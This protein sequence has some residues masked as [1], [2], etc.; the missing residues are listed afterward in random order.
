MAAI[1]DAPFASECVSI[2]LTG[3]DSAD[4]IRAR[5]AGNMLEDAVVVSPI[6]IASVQAHS[7]AAIA[8]A[9]P[10]CLSEFGAAG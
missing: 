1:M 3:A 6:L 7:F 4:V 5:W 2:V 9:A 8:S 10:L